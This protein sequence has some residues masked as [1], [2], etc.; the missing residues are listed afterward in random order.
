LI[1]RPH[2]AQAMVKRGYVANKN[3]AFDKYIGNNKQL[4]CTNLSYWWEK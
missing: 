1:V 2:I 3:E 4:L